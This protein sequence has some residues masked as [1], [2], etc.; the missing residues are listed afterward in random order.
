MTE[1]YWAQKDEVCD[2]TAE[3]SPPPATAIHPDWQ[4]NGL[5]HDLFFEP[6]DWAHQSFWDGIMLVQELE[7]RQ[8][9]EEYQNSVS[10]D[11]LDWRVGDE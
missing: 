3:P 1:F 5:Y 8:W 10:S 7:E 9:D 11:H 4:T 6:W 2:G